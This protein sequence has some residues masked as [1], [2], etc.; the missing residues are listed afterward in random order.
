[1]SAGRPYNSVTPAWRS[2]PCL[3]VCAYKLSCYLN[4]T[5]ATK[6]ECARMTG[7]SRVTV[8]K[9]WNTVDWEGNDFYIFQHVFYC[10]IYSSSTIEEVTVECGV[11]LE[12]ARLKDEIR[13]EY[14]NVYRS[15]EYDLNRVRKSFEIYT[16]PKRAI[17]KG[18]KRWKRCNYSATA[19]ARS[20]R[21]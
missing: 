19:H 2:K 7:S 5:E 14:V 8:I 13:N 3:K 17:W 6:S 11:T 1:M 12:T 20:I 4:E 10:R 15:K 18:K 21:A 16:R 9:W